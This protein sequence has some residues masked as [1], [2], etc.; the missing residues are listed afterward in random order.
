MI[1]SQKHN[2]SWEKHFESS[3]NV[4]CNFTYI[5]NEA[6]KLHI[7]ITSKQAL[8]TKRLEGDENDGITK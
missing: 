8:E 2:K 3:N 7:E 5:A 1:T 6:V 4:F